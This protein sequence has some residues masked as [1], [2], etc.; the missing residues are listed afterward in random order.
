MAD[1]DTSRLCIQIINAHFGPLVAKVSS[2]LLNRGRLQLSQIV[3]FSGLK[4]RTVRGAIL[5]L[6]QHNLVW[7]SEHEDEGEVLEF[8][9]E[10]CLMRLRFGRFISLA[11]EILGEAASRVV[12]VIL[13]HGKLQQS[14]VLRYLSITD[15]KE[16]SVY[17]Q[18]INRLVIGVYL[19]P[20]TKLS[21][22]SRTDRQLRLEAKFRKEHK[23]IPTPK[24]VIGWKIEAR[25]RVKREEGEEAES[26]G[27]KRKA[28]DQTNQRFNK[29][30]L[31]RKLVEDDV[32]EEETYFRVNHVKF[33]V[34]IRNNIIEKATRERFNHATALVLRA[35]LRATESK[36]L[37][38]DDIRSDPVS[39][40]NISTHLSDDD[41][42]SSGLVLHSN[43]NPSTHTLLKEYI[44]ILACADNPTTEG[45]ASSF[46]TVGGGGTGKVQV[47]FETIC[48]RLRQR[49][50]EAVAR[51]R[52]GDDAVRIIRI[53]LSMNKVDEKHLA[54][55]AMMAHKD[56]RPI[57]S[58]L[59]ADAIISLQEIPRGNDRNPARTKIA[60]EEE[61]IVKSVLE[62]RARSDVMNDESLLTRM[63]REVLREFEDK[64]ERLNGLERRVEEVAFILRD[65]GTVGEKDI[66]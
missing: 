65:L 19:K 63:E 64:L 29:I 48:R 36:Q 25:A 30:C 16:V 57:L 41:D 34:Q 10:A 47:E 39:V 51:E 22:I 49:V 38:L 1:A 9:Q 8:N 31:K 56:V 7:H 66:G 6:I 24:D 20:S 53:L 44:A 54:K 43:R 14:D 18:V 46:V 3:R 15:P 52:Y 59:S 50:L 62:K 28:K 5:A 4:P 32:I 40:A 60:E 2:V 21:H 55:V 42:L 23:G 35:T 13:L 17:L 45:R 27:M 61:P 12:S 37:T 33:N 58:S 26:I 11:K